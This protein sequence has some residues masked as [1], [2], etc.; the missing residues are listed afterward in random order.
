MYLAG[1]IKIYQ[2]EEYRKGLVRP[3]FYMS[4]DDD[5]EEEEEEESV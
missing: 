4:D 3:R 1:H 5:E 2:R